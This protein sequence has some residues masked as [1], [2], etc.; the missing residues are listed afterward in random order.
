MPWSIS[1]I[2][3]SVL[4]DISVLGFYGYIGGYFYMNFGKTK[5]IQN[6]NKY[7]NFFKKKISK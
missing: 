7:L 3:I 4:M 2:K 1:R 5:I 6:L